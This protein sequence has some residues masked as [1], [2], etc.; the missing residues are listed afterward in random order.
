MKLKNLGVVKLK[1]DDTEG[2]FYSIILDTDNGKLYKLIDYHSSIYQS[3]R[4][5]G[6]TSIK[7][8]ELDERYLSYIDD[9]FN[10][11]LEYHNKKRFRVYRPS[12]C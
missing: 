1:E 7:I 11:L 5:V 8:E 12:L 9:L 4:K 3:N 2:K 6:R 10:L